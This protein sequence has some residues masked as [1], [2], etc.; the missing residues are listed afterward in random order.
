MRIFFTESLC[1]EH[2]LK[3]DVKLKCDFI[4]IKSKTFTR[5]FVR[6]FQ[7]SLF[8]LFLSYLL[9][10]ITFFSIC[11]AN[12][13]FE[14]CFMVS[15]ASFSEVYVRLESDSVSSARRLFANWFSSI[16]KNRQR[17]RCYYAQAF[18]K[19]NLKRNCGARLL[20]LTKHKY[21]RINNF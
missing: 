21:Y 18:Y 16:I 6:I 5:L 9:R 1:T 12:D 10:N 14:V 3:A 15:L 8:S 2:S 7:R 11:Y 19:C 17:K 13:I 20:G 4:F